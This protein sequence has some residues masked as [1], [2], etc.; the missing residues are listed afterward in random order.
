MPR[1][2]LND[3]LIFMAVVD[4]GSFIAGGQAVGLSR[5]A[6]GKAVIRLEDRLGVRLLNR[7]TR[8]LSLTEEGRMF[9]ERGLRILVSVDEAE[10]SV[11]G[12]DST[13]RGVLRLT[14]DDAFGRLVVLPLLEKYLRAWP[15]IQVEVSFTDRLADIVEEGFDLAIRIGATAT[16]TRLVSR[17]I[18]TY[19]AR[20]CA[21]PSYLAERGEPRD[22]DDLAV[23]DCLIS[24]GRNQRQGWRFRGEGGS[25]I[26]ARGRSRLRLDS[27]EAIRDAALAGLGIALLPDFLVTDDLAAGRLR[28]ILADFETDDAKIVTL[29]PDKRLLEPRVRRFIDLIVEELG[30][31]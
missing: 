9:Y 20:L 21:S 8:T 10:A 1:T 24:A 11:A 7:T 12:Q 26:K 22:V 25:W 29:Y 2:N 27:G 17:V 18:A 15:D 28:Q 14:V 4:A 3:I 13:P 23:H 19:K 16:D 31:G 30:R 6:A 5:S